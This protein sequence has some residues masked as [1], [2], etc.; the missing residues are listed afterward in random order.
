MDANPLQGDWIGSPDQR[1]SCSVHWGHL[2]VVRNGSHVQGRCSCFHEACSALPSKQKEQGGFC[3][4]NRVE[5]YLWLCL[6]LPSAQHTDYSWKPFFVLQD[7]FSKFSHEADTPNLFSDGCLCSPCPHPS[8]V[9]PQRGGQT[10]LIAQH[11]GLWMR[12][13]LA[14]ESISPLLV[15]GKSLNL[16]KPQFYWMNRNSTYLFSQLSSGFRWDILSDRHL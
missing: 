13:I 1:L 2:W 3:D 10:L 7:T 12:Q 11:W 9:I 5:G 8:W 6:G 14:P 4:M 15:L 16:S